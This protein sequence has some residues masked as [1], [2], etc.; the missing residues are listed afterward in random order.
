MHERTAAITPSRWKAPLIGLTCGAVLATV[1]LV[2]FLRGP[3][4]PL[5]RDTL[6]Q[7]RATWRQA[8]IPSYRLAIRVHGRQ[9]NEHRVFVREGKVIDMTT[10]GVKPPER[11]WRH[12]SVTGMFAMLDQELTSRAEGVYGDSPDSVV[13]QVHFDEDRG[14]P[15]H[16]LRHIMGERQGIEWEVTSFVVE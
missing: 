4:E 16:F 12:W 8:K 6:K 7:A 11:T 3:G 1:F 9:Q 14:Y 5:S 13:M 15:R 10:N 2:L